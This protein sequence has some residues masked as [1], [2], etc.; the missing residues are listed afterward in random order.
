MEGFKRWQR[1][2]EAEYRERHRDH[3]TE[4]N[5]DYR[6]RKRQEELEKA[7]RKWTSAQ[8]AVPMAARA[9]SFYCSPDAAAMFKGG[10]ASENTKENT[11]E[12]Q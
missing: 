4:Y 2:Q 6:R 1:D 12:S 8:W 7:Q 3:I 10:M 11:K 9:V 5:R